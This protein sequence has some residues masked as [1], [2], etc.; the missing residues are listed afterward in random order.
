ML[1][2]AFGLSACGDGE[3]DESVD[4]KITV[5][6]AASL[7]EAFTDLG[8]VYEDEHE[9]SKV[10]FS[11][12]ASSGLASQ[13]N[14]GAPADVY[15]SADEPNMQKVAGE[16]M[17]EG[18]PRN[19]AGN[20]L[21]IVTPKGN[22]GEVKSLSDLANEDLTVAVCAPEVPCGSAAKTLFEKEG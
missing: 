14:S 6:A 2:L 8:K 17:I 16:K 22:P 13:I 7:T 5:F 1:L 10:V 18:E 4:G 11:F 12:A 3:S 15:A 20:V 9:G 19:F 21:E